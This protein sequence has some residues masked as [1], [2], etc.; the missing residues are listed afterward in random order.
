M[1][2]SGEGKTQK[3]WGLGQFYTRGERVGGVM[4]LE[5]GGNG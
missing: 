1:R 3:I 2:R 5:E 4:T